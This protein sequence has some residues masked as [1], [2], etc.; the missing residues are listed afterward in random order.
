MLQWQKHDIP[1]LTLLFLGS[2]TTCFCFPRKF[3]NPSFPLQKATTCKI[4]A[5]MFVHSHFTLPLFIWLIFVFIF[6]Y[7]Y[8]QRTYCMPLSAK[9]YRPMWQFFHPTLSKFSLV[10]I[11]IVSYSISISLQLSAF[12]PQ[13]LQAQWGGVMRNVSSH[14]I[15]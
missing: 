2:W 14:G 11:M 13:Q 12:Q 4:T 8:A 6:G 10:Q 1:Y 7:T 15:L 3:K 9:H 5:W